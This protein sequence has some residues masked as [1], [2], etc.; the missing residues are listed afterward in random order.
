M[1]KNKYFTRKD[2]NKG[3]KVD[4]RD[5]VNNE[6]TGDWILIRG[7]DSDKF[8][9]ADGKGRRRILQH[10]QDGTVENEDAYDVVIADVE[11]ECVA[12][13][14][15]KWCFDGKEETPKVEDVKEFLEE[16]PQIADL[17]NREAA[18][19]ANFSTRTCEPST[20]TSKKK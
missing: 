17:L 14:V 1:A 7:M 4:L 6:L 18:N 11:R 5:P 3:F 15:I 8:K 20:N 19:R 16:A 9:I 2:S 13:L 12:A 10:V